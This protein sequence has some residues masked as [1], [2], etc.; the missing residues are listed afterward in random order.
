MAEA[1]ESFNVDL[2]PRIYSRAGEVF[3]S[4]WLSSTEATCT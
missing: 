2:M 3:D 4:W 1:S